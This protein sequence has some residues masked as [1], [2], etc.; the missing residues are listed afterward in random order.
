[1]TCYYDAPAATLH[2]TKVQFHKYIIISARP[3]HPNLGHRLKLLPLHAHSSIYTVIRLLSSSSSTTLG[4]SDTAVRDLH[5]FVNGFIIVNLPYRLKPT[6]SSVILVI[7]YEA[8]RSADPPPPPKKKEKE[9]KKT[10]TP[11]TTAPHAHGQE[12]NLKTLTF[13]MDARGG[14]G[15]GV[16]VQFRLSVATVT[17]RSD[18]CRQKCT[19]HRSLIY[20]HAK[21]ERSQ[22]TT[23]WP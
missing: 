7:G 14:V 13:K 8:G 18:Q 12:Q 10:A 1:M 6:T 3:L 16:R 4:H 22:Q 17:I 9:Y 21:F 19:V 5:S 20:H 23:D 2:Y 11:L 15:W